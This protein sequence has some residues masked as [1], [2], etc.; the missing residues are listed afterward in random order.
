ML[1]GIE[2]AGIAPDRDQPV[3]DFR[4]PQSGQ[5]DAEAVGIGKLRVVLSSAGEVGIGLDAVA[6]IDYNQEGRPIGQRLGILL[7]L[8]AGPQH[9]GVPCPGAP[10][11]VPPTAASRP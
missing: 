8:A 9:R 4:P 6:D 5:Q 7:G 1:A 3:A 10:D 2:R 11:A